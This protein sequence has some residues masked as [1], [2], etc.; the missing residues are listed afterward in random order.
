MSRL[1]H[2][3]S[4]VQNR[5]ALGLFL[6]ALAWASLAFAAV[7]WL[8]V[9]LDRIFLLHLPKPMVWLYAGAAATAL[10]AVIY[11]VVK[12]PGA[13]EAA[14]AI[15]Q[16]L[17]LKEKVSTAL[18][19][20]SSDDAFAQAAVRDAEAT[21]QNIVLNLRQH[22][23]TPFPKPAYATFAVAILAL[24]SLRIDPMNLFDRRE[25]AA[26]AEQEQAQVEAA[27]EN[28]KRA[29]ATVDRMATSSVDPEAIKLARADLQAMLAPSMNDAAKMNRTAARAM[30]DLDQA[31]KQQIKNSAN[32]ALTQDTMKA[33]RM[34][35]KPV[36]GQGP[37]ADAHRAIVEA[38]FTEAIDELEAAINNFEKMD[39]KQQ[40]EAAQQ[41]QKLA[42]QMQAMANNP[43]QQEKMQQQLQQMGMNQQQAQQAQQLMQQAAQGNQQA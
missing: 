28:V 23:P 14:V 24:L 34:N 32:Y 4:A 36:E 42:A 31:I 10:A 13:K 18:Y 38:K 17:G 29:L 21:A 3:V 20:R 30:Q 35:Q 5:L 33:M 2:H 6:K 1:D 19:I 11:A 43:A 7:A 27:K 16:K 25:K 8:A 12:R 15:D 40:Q 22:F 39:K 37:V 26:K 41:M 9:L